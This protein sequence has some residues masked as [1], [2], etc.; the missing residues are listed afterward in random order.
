MSS[1]QQIA[2]V[3]REAKK[4]I[5]EVLAYLAEQQDDRRPHL[6]FL[7]FLPDG[8]NRHAVFAIYLRGTPPPDDERRDSHEIPSLVPDHQG[9][10]PAYFNHDGVHDTIHVIGEQR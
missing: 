7:G 10:A 5:P 9:Q 4:K 6:L 3:L 8:T 2:L 1:P